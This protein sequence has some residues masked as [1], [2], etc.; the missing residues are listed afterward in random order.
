MWID[1]K[2]AA[3]I[4]NVGQSTLREAVF[5]NSQKYPFIR[6]EN[7]GKKGRGG[8]RLLFEIEPS[9]LKMALK[10]KKIS[11]NA[12]VFTLDDGGIK[13]LKMDE[14]FP[15]LKPNS[16]KITDES[17]I[18]SVFKNNKS[19]VNLTYFELT[20]KQK[21][22]ADKKIKLIK[23]QET[24]GLSVSDFCKVKNLSK[25]SFY[26][27]K[28]E[29]KKGG[30][31]AL[32][33]K[34]G[35]HRKDKTV[36]KPWMKEFIL[37]K[38]RSYG[39]G[40][41]NL[42]ECLD[43]MHK[44]MMIRENYDYIGFLKCEVKPYCDTGVIKR[45]LNGYYKNRKLE[46]TLITKGA[47]KAKSYLQP[48]FGNQS[49]IV[50]FRNQCWQIDSSPLDVMVVV[51]KKI[52]RADILSI[53]DVYSGRCVA[54]VVT[55][56]NALTLVRLIARAFEVLGKPQYI[57]GDNGKDYLSKQFQELLKGLGIGYDAAIAYCGD[58]KGK[59]E[60]HFRTLQHAKI[61][62]L[63]GYVGFN[64]RIREQIEQRTPKK[65]RHAKDKFGNAKKTNLKYLL[66]L[67]DMKKI[68]EAEVLKWD[69]TNVRRKGAKSPLEIWNSDN[70]PIM[71]V[72]YAEFLLYA[73]TG[74]TRT[75]SKKGI[76]FN[77]YTFISP[78][79]PNVGT[80]VV[81]RQ[82][83]D[84]V[85]EIFVFDEKGKFICT[86]K[87]QSLAGMSADEFNAAKKLFKKDMKEIRKVIDR[88]EFSEF[89]KLNADYDLELMKKAHRE[90]LSVENR[91][92]S[93]DVSALKE[94]IE[95]SREVFNI[96]NSNGE[97]STLP[98]PRAVKKK[99]IGFDELIENAV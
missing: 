37:N 85:S 60:R 82:N 25:T 97:Y 55:Q 57:K 12:R 29:Y 71:C 31:V 78:L 44:E 79:L 21:D 43:G 16:E 46:Y 22:E 75:V 32:A 61:S 69:I 4:F 18:C 92:L 28:D 36:L 73:G 6:L 81:V 27:W 56:G 80:K 10:D 76:N 49:E 41:F 53:I 14:I 35:M 74:D 23:E 65:E 84:D 33:D 70:T 58:E 39:A 19:S 34:S 24:S 54:D 48:S 15:E 88:A 87:E 30:A 8:K 96:K 98:K 9:D 47:D 90:S 66:S 94:K 50:T 93:N 68:F 2:T 99:F 63:P 7:T 40:N 59:V 11:L 17:Q 3:A 1:T 45:F 20:Q 91:V 42:T 26:R 62:Q 77:A 52:I 38:F 5:R 67:E 13:E 83:I 89:T 95:L 86:A 64:L 51:D 72:D